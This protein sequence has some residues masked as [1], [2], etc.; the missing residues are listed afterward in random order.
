MEHRA[1][2]KRRTDGY[3]INMTS[4]LT[5]IFKACLLVCQWRACLCECNYNLYL[6][7]ME[8]TLPKDYLFRV[9]KWNVS[10]SGEINKRVEEALRIFSEGTCDEES[11]AVCWL[12]SDCL[13][14][15]KTTLLHSFDLNEVYLVSV[16]S[17][18]CL[19]NYT[20]GNKQECIENIVY[21]ETCPQTATTATT[22][23]AMKPS[24][25]SHA[26]TSNST[27]TVLNEMSS[28]P[29][30]TPPQTTTTIKNAS[31]LTAS[32]TSY[33]R[34][35][36]SVLTLFAISL[37]ANVLLLLCV[38]YLWTQQ[39]HQLRRQSLGSGQTEL[40]EVEAQYLRR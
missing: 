17:F 11:P 23:E 26:T 5:W 7:E 8:A 15:K 32:T 39:R 2:V 4:G 27:N 34:G 9:R 35:E 40:D 30:R 37:M 19:V 25:S 29:P 20:F 10:N 14:I 22:E 16:K 3:K 38:V 18:K 31:S 21:S 12:I 13:P 24:S 28:I 33:S 1:E 36:I 6:D